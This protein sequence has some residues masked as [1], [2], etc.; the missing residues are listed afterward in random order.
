MQFK[1]FSKVFPEVG[2]SFYILYKKRNLF[3]FT[4]TKY[5]LKIVI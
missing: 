1:I 5:T 3:N 4:S 2:A